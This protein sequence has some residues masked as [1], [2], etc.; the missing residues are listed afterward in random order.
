MCYDA[1]NTKQC[2]GGASECPANW[3]SLSEEEQETAVTEDESILH[4]LCDDEDASVWALNSEDVC[5]EYAWVRG[6]S[7]SLHLCL[8][9]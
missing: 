5:Y 4:C 8:S 9:T 2:Q 7:A 3:D 6:F 1:I